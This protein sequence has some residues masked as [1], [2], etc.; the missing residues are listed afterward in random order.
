MLL[1][2]TLHCCIL[3]WKHST[4]T[5]PHFALVTCA[6]LSSYIMTPH[7]L[8][9]FFILILSNPVS[10]VLPY[11]NILKLLL[12]CHACRLCD[13]NHEQHFLSPKSEVM[14]A[15]GCHYNFSNLWLSS[16]GSHVAFFCLPFV[17]V[18]L[19]QISVYRRLRVCVSN[20]KINVN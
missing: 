13:K 6:T 2:P 15:Y 14:S 20:L 18:I 19:C 3:L 1:C 7:W 17:V 8:T 9:C 5:L 16:V 4:P 11:C 12:F 10:S